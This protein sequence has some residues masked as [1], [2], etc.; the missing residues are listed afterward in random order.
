MADSPMIRTLQKMFT[1]T[2]KRAVD[3]SW[4]ALASYN[5]QPVAYVNPQIAEQLS[6]VTAAVNAI[7]GAIGTLPA[8]VY[9]V[10][11][12]GREVDHAHPIARLIEDGPNSYQ[13]WS[14]FV[15]WLT[16][17][18][19]LYGN[20]LAAIRSDNRGQ[21]TELASY[22]WGRVAVQTVTERIIYDCTD[23]QGRTQRLL[24]GDVLHLKDRSDDGLLGRS[25]LSRTAPVIE[26]ALQMQQFGNALYRNG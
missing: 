12:K 5:G 20:G 4:H 3:P 24:Q 1:P 8:Y 18:A 26:L 9:R 23:H 6:A 14:E 13:T 17:Q 25:R 7:S 21:V 10:T 22:P 11:D 15:E 2:E 19:L 16:A